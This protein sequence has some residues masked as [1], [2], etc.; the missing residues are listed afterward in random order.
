MLLGYAGFMCTWGIEKCCEYQNSVNIIAAHAAT[1]Y[2]REVGTLLE[3]FID[4]SPEVFI[5]DQIHVCWADGLILKIG[6]VRVIAVW[7]NSCTAFSKFF[8]L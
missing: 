5:V 8:S 7:I 6:A 3:I 1:C 2:Q 4:Q